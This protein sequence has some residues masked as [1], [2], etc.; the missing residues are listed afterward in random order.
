M[1]CYLCGGKQD[2]MKIDHRDMKTAPC[3][4]CEAAIQ[5]CLDGYPSEDED[6]YTYIEP[7]PEE[8]RDL[9]I[10]DRKYYD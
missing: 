5:E 1:S 6:G 4:T 2:D 3:G 7:S 10:E 9:V 8:F